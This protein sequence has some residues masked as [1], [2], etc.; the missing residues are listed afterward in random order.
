MFATQVNHLVH[1]KSVGE[2]SPTEKRTG[3][4]G[5][6]PMA[7]TREERAELIER[8]ARENAEARERIEA[9]RLKREENPFEYDLADRRLT[10]DPSDLHF[11]AAVQEKA[12]G[13]P[14]VAK[15][16]GD[17][18][19][20]RM[21]PE[22]ALAPVP[23]A[24]TDWSGWEAWM[25]GHL[26]ILRQEM[27]AAVSKALGIVTVETRRELRAEIEEL[28]SALREREERA[29]A[30]AEVKRQYEGERVEH[31]A[32]RLSSALAARDA[33]I[34]TLEQKLALLCR[35]LSL[36]EHKLPEGL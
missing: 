17:G 16:N 1:L 14:P 30:I 11:S 3:K 32:L 12:E 13:G 26:D 24:D 9:L 2:N 28:R 36:G 7:M 29:S 25:Q 23:A 34:E 33:K 10:D 4:D 22:N 35:F 15:S 20:Y 8:L 21:G 31:E 19:V 27:S 18:L 5:S 6:D